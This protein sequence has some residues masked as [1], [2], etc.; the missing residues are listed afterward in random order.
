MG[1]HDGNGSSVL[2][3]EHCHRLINMRKKH[4][5]EPRARPSVVFARL[6][7]A[8]AVDGRLPEI[9]EIPLTEFAAIPTA[10]CNT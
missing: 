6:L 7:I 4:T 10:G 8:A 2:L 9:W 1:G 5:A 3:G